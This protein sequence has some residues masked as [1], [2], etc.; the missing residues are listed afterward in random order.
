M[1]APLGPYEDKVVR[2]CFARCCSTLHRHKPNDFVLRVHLLARGIV[3]IAMRRP[4]T[5]LE[6]CD[7]RRRRHPRRAS[8]SPSPS[9]RAS[10]SVPRV[11]TAR[12][13][14]RIPP[15]RLPV[16]QLLDLGLVGMGAQSALRPLP[17]AEWLPSDA[18]IKKADAGP[19]LHGVRRVRVRDASNCAA[20]RRGGGG[21]RALLS[22]QHIPKRGSARARAAH[23]LQHLPAPAPWWSAPAFA[24]ARRTRRQSR[25]SSARCCLIAPPPGSRRRR[26][27]RRHS[28]CSARARS[29]ADAYGGT[30]PLS[31][32]LGV[33]RSRC[34]LG[35]AASPSDATRSGGGRV[36]RPPSVFAL[37]SRYASLAASSRAVGGRRRSRR[38]S[39]RMAA[40]SARRR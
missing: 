34:A 26:F 32:Q 8:L 38:R 30:R 23:L 36:A 18:S 4:K 25:T 14:S 22:R 11:R 7:P 39:S 28:G 40:C 33:L 37:L 10:T 13:S 20:A 21:R 6:R 24:R 29:I 2:D 3:R 12:C 15:L 27:A 5:S 1:G 17:H 9:A 35:T 31:A 19:A 16:A